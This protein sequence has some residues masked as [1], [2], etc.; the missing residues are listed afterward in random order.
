MEFG[1]EYETWGSAWGMSGLR[2]QLEIQV[3]FKRSV[4]RPS[5]ALSGGDRAKDRTLGALGV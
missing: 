4:T 2:C 1:K 5:L 3:D